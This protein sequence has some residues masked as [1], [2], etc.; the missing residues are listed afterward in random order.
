MPTIY[1][2]IGNSDDKLTQA[3][4]HDFIHDVDV[5]IRSTAEQ[6]HGEWF[7]GPRSPWQNACWCFDINQDQELRANLALFVLA[8]KYNQNSIAWAVA[9]TTFIQPT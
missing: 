6:V 3:R 2:S 5:T 8:K 1:V 4:W 7:S 9:E